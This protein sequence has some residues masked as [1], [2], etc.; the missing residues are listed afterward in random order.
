MII[1]IYIVYLHWSFLRYR[2]MGRTPQMECRSSHNKFHPIGKR[3]RGA[4]IS[5]RVYHI[6]NLFL[7]L[8]LR[9]PRLRLPVHSHI[10]HIRARLAARV[11]C[12]GTIVGVPL[13]YERHGACCALNGRCDGRVSK[14]RVSRG[15]STS[16]APKSASSDGPKSAWMPK[17]LLTQ[18]PL[19]SLQVVLAASVVTKG[20]KGMTTL[21][22]PQPHDVESGAVMFARSR[23]PTLLLLSLFRVFLRFV[24]PKQLSHSASPSP[25]TRA[26]SP[27]VS[28]VRPHDANSH[29]GSAGGLS[30]ARGHGKATHVR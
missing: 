16:S 20:G 24:C 4:Q 29:R 6:F 11:V 28:P 9:A 5:K 26:H 27:C 22:R 17:L 3:R 15:L 18:H 8:F 23:S 19:R 13:A 12:N 1:N 30:K 7:K 25:R 10:R 2:D 14:C 21:K